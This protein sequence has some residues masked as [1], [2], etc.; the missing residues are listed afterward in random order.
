MFY[1]DDW[2]G[3]I[4]KSVVEKYWGPWWIVE[5]VTC[6]PH[7][8]GGQ[9]VPAEK[10]KNFPAKEVWRGCR[11]RNMNTSSRKWNALNIYKKHHVSLVCVWA[12]VC[13]CVLDH[14]VGGERGL[15]SKYCRFCSLI[16]TYLFLQGR[17]V[18]FVIFY[19]LYFSIRCPS[20]AGCG[21]Q[22]KILFVFVVCYNH[23]A[24]TINVTAEWTFLSPLVWTALFSATNPNM[25]TWLWR[26]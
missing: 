19:I 20:V 5:K 24:Y 17:P 14:V 2:Y 3:N 13:L 23:S 4:D 18:L 9:Y 11:L 25:L 8:H 6:K 21:R 15:F 12:C 26:L 22:L 10:C 7:V 16:F 1:N